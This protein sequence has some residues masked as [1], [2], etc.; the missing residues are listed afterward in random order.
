MINALSLKERLI[1]VTSKIPAAQEKA[2]AEMDGP[3]RGN[4]N[5]NGGGGDGGTHRHDGAG[6]RRPYNLTCCSGK[7]VPALRSTM[8]DVYGVTVSLARR[9]KP[10]GRRRDRIRHRMALKRGV[11]G[12]STRTR[13]SCTRQVF[14]AARERRSGIALSCAGLHCHD[15]ASLNKEGR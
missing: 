3:G 1:D 13:A 10:P 14:G 4:Y 15:C 7:A 12:V 6:C 11:C 5:G 8:A 2:R 9:A